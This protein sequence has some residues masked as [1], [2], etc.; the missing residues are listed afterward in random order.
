MQRTRAVNFF[1]FHVQSDGESHDGCSSLL[2]FAAQRSD[3]MHMPQRTSSISNLT[4]NLMVTLSVDRAGS[5]HPLAEFSE[6][7]SLSLIRKN[8]R[9]SQAQT[10]LAAYSSAHHCARAIGVE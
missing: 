2:I 10:A 4:E 1:C 9:P 7:H 3:L 8:M 6:T 5:S